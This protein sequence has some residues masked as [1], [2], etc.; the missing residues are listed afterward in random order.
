MREPSPR[1]PS[2]EYEQVPDSEDDEEEAD[3]GAA[4]EHH[5]QAPER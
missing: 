5:G 1:Q 2:E 4:L 3:G